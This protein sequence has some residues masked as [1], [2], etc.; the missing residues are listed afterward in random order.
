[1]RLPVRDGIRRRHARRTSVGEEGAGVQRFMLGLA[2]HIVAAGE[3]GQG[4][5]SRQGLLHSAGTSNTST[6]PRPFRNW[7]V[8]SSL[9]RGSQAVTTRKN[10]LCDAVSK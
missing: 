7:R 3:Q 8:S 10:P 1:M 2:R 5:E 9:K 4:E 6:G